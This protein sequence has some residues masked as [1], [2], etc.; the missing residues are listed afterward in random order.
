MTENGGQLFSVESSGNKDKI[1]RVVVENTL[2]DRLFDYTVPDEFKDYVFI[3]SKVRVNFSGRKCGGYVVEL[4]ESSPYTAKLKPILSV[5]NPSPLILPP[6]IKLARWMADYYLSPLAK[7]IET[8]LPSP[9]RSGEIKER[10]LLYVEPAADFKGKL[11]K[12]QQ[13][14]VDDLRR[15]G[16][17]WMSQV[18]REFKCSPQILKKL[19]ELGAVTIEERQQRRDPLRKGRVVPTQ[20][21]PLNSDQ[22]AALDMI[23]ATLPRVN[24]QFI[25]RN[26]EIMA[27]PASEEHDRTSKPVVLFGVTGSGKTEVYLQSIAAALERG[28]GAIILVP[29]ISLTPQTVHR[30]ASRFGNK[31]AVLHSALS[32]G[33]RY[34]EWQRIRKGEARVVVGPRSAI[35]API[36]N[37]G[38]I[39]VDEEHEPSYKQEEQPRYNARDAAVMRGYIEKCAVVLGSATPSLETWR[40]I[41][42]GKYQIA[43]LKERAVKGAVMPLVRIVDMAEE[44]ARTGHVNVFSQ[45][46]LSAIHERLLRHEQVILFLNRRGFAT[47][48][49]CPTC[50]YVETC[51][52]CDI[53][54][55]YHKH[56]D[57]LR[58][59]ICSQ[60]KRSPV[61]CPECGDPQIR[62]TGVGT[63]RIETII[64][65]CF[66]RASVGRMDAD[67]TSRK[68]SHDDILNA[69]KAG[70]TD[71]L[72]G[73]QMIAK[74]LDF[75]R[76]TLV[77][78][79]NADSSLQIP[80]FRAGERTFQL[81]AQ[82]SGR[83]GRGI[84][85]GEVIIQT[86][87]PEH[88]AVLM[89]K[90]ENFTGF[91]SEELPE[92]KELN[93]PPYIHLTNLTLTGPAERL[94]EE[95]LIDLARTIKENAP[96]GMAISGVSPAS[97][98]KADDLF[99]FQL[100][101]RHPSSQQIT[102]AIKAALA[103]KEIPH[104][105]RLTVD[106]D[107]YSF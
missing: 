66:P 54:F 62:Y 52:K 81:L 11:T 95:L 80:D 30:F 63:Q 10:V 1:I 92:R 4:P 79:I 50:G 55:T 83:T 21:L 104:P 8:L 65:T 47:S 70:E 15:V 13:E 60:W 96:Q 32:N 87:S 14:L 49:T 99:R 102:A 94:T 22:S 17:G 40:N 45:D 68:Q 73:T 20:P 39:I 64:H 61:K 19:H 28:Q 67:S 7:A 85:P 77:G 86:Y 89:A 51:E 101:L 23:L 26:S 46:L 88:R 82:V 41:E 48:L 5:D 71:I 90:S 56:D 53:P 24:S 2:P 31:I 36:E 33:E 38:L 76:V 84:L 100:I 103:Q 27:A 93:Y 3:G 98:A 57:C 58:C 107:A 37:L 6:L 42:L 12:R 29:E 43:T 75:P 59:H 9:V 106:I 69:F 16:G 91:A 78:I 35:F 105:F 97:L 74:G 18:C 44:N 25:I 72:I 34:D